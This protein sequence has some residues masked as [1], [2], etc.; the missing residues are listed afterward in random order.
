MTSVSV[1]GAV[2]FTLTMDQ[3]HLLEHEGGIILPPEFRSEW[4]A[5]VSTADRANRS[6][7]AV[8]SFVESGLAAVGEGELAER[9]AIP[10]TVYLS[11]FARPT[12]VFGVRAW[13]AERTIIQTVAVFDGYAAQLVRTQ[14]LTDAGPANENLAEFSAFPLGELRDQLTRAIAIVGPDVSSPSE[15]PWATF[16]M[17]DAGALVAAIGTGDPGLIEAV[18]RRAGAVRSVHPVDRAAVSI[19]SGFTAFAL[20]GGRIGRHWFHGDGGWYELSLDLGKGPD[21]IAAV[22]GSLV[23]FTAASRSSI[24][25][26]ITL[27]VAELTGALVG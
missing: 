11:F 25:T 26:G 12:V 1:G 6:A 17:I 13:N 22:D 5:D 15:P 21:A 9:L 14:R 3:L 8:Q 2:R 10:F 23:Q 16:G 19:D 24:T 20:S 4:G 7:A 18:A 27:L